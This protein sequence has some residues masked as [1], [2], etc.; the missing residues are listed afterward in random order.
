ML[1]RCGSL[2]CVGVALL[3]GTTSAQDFMKLF[4]K[5]GA[6]KLLKQQISPEALK[7][8]VDPN[9]LEAEP[10]TVRTADGWTLV[11][12][13]YRP[14]QSNGL[15]PVILCHG[16]NYNAHFWDLDPS[17][18][19]P[20]YLSEQGYD[21]WSADLRGC[22]MS[23]KWVWKVDQTSSV[24]VGGAIRNLSG[25]RLAPTGYATVDPRF[26]NWTLDDHITYDV[27]AIVFLVKQQTGAK[28]VTWIGH[29]MGGIVALGHLCRY[30]NPGIGRLV[31][32]GSQMT[33]PQGQVAT[34]LTTELLKTRELQLTK[35][36][37]PAATE[38]SV[39][40]LFFN[41]QHVKKE[42]YDALGTWA[43]DVP[44]VGLLKQYTALTATGELRDAGNTFSYTRNLRNVQVP[45]LICGGAMDQLAPPAVQKYLYDN[46]GARDKQ[47]FIVGKTSGLPVDSGHNDSLV[48]TTSKQQFYPVIDQWIRKR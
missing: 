15:A 33:M 11:L 24:I 48:G 19:L 1:V 20:R 36:A 3:F 31:C 5:D 14:R 40:N 38:K 10:Y 44:A 7:P 32:V 30:Q 39:H 22:G 17:C 26:A 34:Q 8:I 28:D 35:K 29:S 9:K 45:I 27:A 21:V 12:H 25:G 6:K 47:L 23:Q 37:I 13:R 46:V 2:A 4:E 42:V 43:K 41:E 16:L 18:S